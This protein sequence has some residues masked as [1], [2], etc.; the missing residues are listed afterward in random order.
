MISYVINGG[1]E[2]NGEIKNSGSK[3]SALPI[4]ATAILNPNPVVFYNVPDIDDVKTTLKILKV[5]G[6]KITRECDKITISSFNLKKTE[7][8]EE[9][10]H[11]C[12]S[13]VIL[14]GAIVGRMKRATFSF[15]G[16]C[17]IGA[18]PINLHIKALKELGIRFTEKQ[19]KIICATKTIRGAKLQLEFPSVGATENIILSS[20]YAKGVTRISNAA[21]EPEIKDLA[22]CL[23]KMGAKIYGAGT[24]NIKIV[25]VNKLNPVQYKIMPDRIEAGTFLCGAAITHGKI[26]ITNTNP[27]DLSNVL[28]KLKEIGCDISIKNNEIC[29]KAPEKIKSIS[30]STEPYPGFPT[31]LEPIFTALL[32]KAKGTSKI[33]EN[34]FENRFEFCKELSKMGADIKINKNGREISIKG[35]EKISGNVVKSKDLRGGAS[36]VLEGLAAEG[37]T[38]VEDAEYILRGYEKLDEKLLSLGANI[39]IINK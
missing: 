22:N 1:K 5:L 20:I 24:S 39:K 2:L 3:N 13:T 17:N 18:R 31:D 9:L 28:Y 34:I 25:G 36:L 21:K 38:V 32:T 14:V 8:P 16:G 4:L 37:K 6:C 29:L 30:I 12:R 15:P 11:R 33:E 27:S 7:I 23:K 35:V 26:R 10:M 19:N